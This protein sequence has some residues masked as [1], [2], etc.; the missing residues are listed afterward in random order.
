MYNQFFGLQKNPFSMTPD[1][2]F[3]HLTFQCREVL[4]GLTYAI[5]DHKGLVILIGEAGT[6]KTTLLTRFLEAIPDKW[7]QPI[8]IL[9]PTLTAPELLE[10]ILL[11][12]GVTEIPPT[13][14]R[15]LFLVEQ[16]LLEADKNGKTC[17]LFVDEAHKLS[18]EVLEEIRLIGNIERGGRKLLPIALLGQTDL[19]DILNRPDLRQLKQRVALRFSIGPLSTS[20]IAAY[21]NFRWQKAS[22]KLPHP[23]LDDAVLEI[24]RFSGGI[25]RLINAICDNALIL[26]FGSNERAVTAR[27]IRAVSMDLDLHPDSKSYPEADLVPPSGS[28]AAKRVVSVHPDGNGLAAG[29]NGRPRMAP[30]S[31]PLPVAPESIRIREAVTAPAPKVPIFRRFFRWMR[32]GIES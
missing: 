6:G 26:V 11:S 22:G 25:P 3:L 21:L 2:S 19:G 13:K 1:P 17:A 27:H 9:N 16:H 28:P 12:I 18:P 30:I 8:V 24:E 15:R 31:D 29:V 4:A 10:A 32:P 5:L 14:P 7:L 23:F 20:D